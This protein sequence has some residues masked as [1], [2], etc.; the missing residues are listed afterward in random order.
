MDQKSDE[1]LEKIRKELTAIIE[2]EK[3]GDNVVKLS[4]KDLM[5]PNVV[6]VVPAKPRQPNKPKKGIGEPQKTSSSQADSGPLRRKKSS[7]DTSE[8]SS[9]SSETSGPR[10]FEALERSGF[11]ES[12]AVKNID[13]DLQKM[14]LELK[15]SYDLFQ[16]I[17]EKFEAIDFRGLKT[18]IRDLHLNNLENDKAKA[19]TTELQKMFENCYNQ[20]RLDKLTSEA[21]QAFR[22]HPGEF[23]DIPELSNFF[24]A[25]SQLEQS[26]ETLK[27]Q[28]RRSNELEKRMCW[29]TEIAYDRMA[30]IRNSVGSDPDNDI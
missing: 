7:S 23:G 24:Q 29:A 1:M 4:N 22:R 20:N 3:K 9:I 15:N 14:Q 6:P 28:R 5:A 21:G 11:F 2:N 25:C 26:L 19:T 30:E 17:G 13:N 18:R 12:P 8:T 27:Q 10:R 16:G